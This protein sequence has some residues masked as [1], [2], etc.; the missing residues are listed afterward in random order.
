MVNMVVIS[1]MLGPLKYS[2]PFFYA[3]VFNKIRI[4]LG[5]RLLK[6]KNRCRTVN[7]TNWSTGKFRSWKT[8]YKIL[9]L[10]IGRLTNAF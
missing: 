8:A 10:R 9:L 5:N 6:Y 7:E 2:I 4:P 1:F 3:D